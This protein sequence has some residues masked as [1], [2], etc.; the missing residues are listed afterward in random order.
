MV[1]EKEAQLPGLSIS[2]QVKPISFS[3]AGSHLPQKTK[4]PKS[5][6]YHLSLSDSHHCI[7][8]SSPTTESNPSPS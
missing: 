5:K 1:G 6:L 2:R 4:A 8:S 7:Q 3:R